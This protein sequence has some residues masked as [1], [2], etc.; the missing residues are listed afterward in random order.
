[1]KNKQP[2]FTQRLYHVCSHMVF[3]DGG[4]V[5]NTLSDSETWRGMLSKQFWPDSGVASDND[6]LFH[7]FLLLILLFL[8]HTVGSFTP[9]VSVNT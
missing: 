4:P 7:V 5:F 1:M 8:F 2:G 6:L 3:A 9:L